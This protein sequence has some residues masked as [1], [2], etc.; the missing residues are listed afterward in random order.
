MKIFCHTNTTCLPIISYDHIDAPT[1][2]HSGVRIGYTPDVLN[3]DVA[4]IAVGLTLSV[5]RNFNQ[6]SRYILLKARFVLKLKVKLQSLLFLC[7]GLY[8][9]LYDTFCTE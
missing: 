2:L 9:A 6:N 4:D 8:N 1:V 7:L 3:S 5:L